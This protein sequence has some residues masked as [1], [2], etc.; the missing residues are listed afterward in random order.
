M[1]RRLI[2]AP[3]PCRKY[4]IPLIFSTVQKKVLRFQWVRRDFL[5]KS[6]KLADALTQGLDSLSFLGVQ[7]QYTAKFIG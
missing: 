2:M 7:R 1:P 4:L 5:V 6:A 3:E